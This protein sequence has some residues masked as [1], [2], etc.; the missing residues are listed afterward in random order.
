MSWHWE[1]K[2][3]IVLKPKTIKELKENIKNGTTIMFSNI[4]SL[5][6]LNK[7]ME[8]IKKD[9][10]LSSTEKDLKIFE[11]EQSMKGHKEQINYFQ[12]ILRE[13]NNKLQELEPA[14]ITTKSK[15]NIDKDK[16]ISNKKFSQ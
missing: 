4:E 11:I 15:Y 10:T 8:E 6:N 5:E 7:K 3:T 2:L 12:K 1:G 14:K 9:K 16:K 13:W